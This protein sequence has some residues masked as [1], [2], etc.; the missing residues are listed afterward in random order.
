M[1]KISAIMD[2]YTGHRHCKAEHGLSYFIETPEF[3]ML[4]DTGQSGMTVEN[5]DAL[6]IP[7]DEIKYLVL[8]H[9]HYDHTGGLKAVLERKNPLDIIAHPDIFLERYYKKPN[10]EEIENIS[11]PFSREELEKMGAN[12]ILTDEPFFLQQNMFTSGEIKRNSP[13]TS[14]K[15][16][17]K[18]EDGKL[19]EDLIWDDQ[20]IY[21]KHDNKLNI[22]CGCSHSG[23]I[24][25]IQQGIESTGLDQINLLMGG[26]HLFLTKEGTFKDIV[27]ELNTFNIK[28]IGISHCTGIHSMP[29]MQENIASEISY[30]GIGDTILID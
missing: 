17:Y 1:Y 22:I 6:S 9:G 23:I 16:L 24:N 18:I 30:F 26:L 14:N 12:F 20:A 8:S 21:I 28:G 11:N 29:F 25:V 5:A 13:Y 15:N 10:N 7:L 3:K 19:S 2:N 4:F 27:Y